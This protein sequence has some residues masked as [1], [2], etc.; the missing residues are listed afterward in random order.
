MRTIQTYILRL[1]MDT[2]EPHALR[3]V[4][5]A[6]ANDEEHAFADEPALL[7]LLRRMSSHIDQVSGEEDLGST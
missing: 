5:R 3:G 6:V 4:I 2:E 1:L 7:Y